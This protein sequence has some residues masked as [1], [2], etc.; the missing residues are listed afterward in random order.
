M[1]RFCIII[2]G[3]VASGKT[4]LGNNLVKRIGGV[5]INYKAF[6]PANIIAKIIL[7]YNP[8]LLPRKYDLSR[9]DSFLLL[10]PTFLSKLHLLIIISEIFYKIYQQVLILILLL[11]RRVVIIDEFLAL[12]LSNYINAYR[13]NI[14]SGNVL[15]L[16]YRL[17]LCFVKLLSLI[18][19]TKYIYIN[20]PP[21]VLLRNW[22]RR[23]HK[24]HYDLSFLALVEYSSKIIKEYINTN[25]KKIEYVEVN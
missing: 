13:L 12:R 19:R 8:E 10:P 4:M 3:P 15:K 24:I 6:G 9:H 20:T 17:D 1:I 16:L 11:F 18:V 22:M 21:P 23:G 2:D 14:I 25:V 5:I 7:K